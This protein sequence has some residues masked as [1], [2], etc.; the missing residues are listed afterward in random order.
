MVIL[1]GGSFDPIHNGHVLLIQNVIEKFSPQRFIVV[2]AYHGMCKN[3]C[4]FSREFR[5]NSVQKAL[6]E[7]PDSILKNIE[8]SDFELKQN[9]PV[10]TYET[11]EE[12]KPDTLLIGSDLDYTKWKNFKNVIDAYIKQILIYPRN[13][14]SP[15]PHSKKEIILN[16]P[17]LDVS[18]SEIISQLSRGES[19]KG[20]VPDS[21]LNYIEQEYLQ[22]N[23]EDSVPVRKI[24]NV[25]F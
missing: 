3:R 5:F 21:V 9:R 17:L 6:S 13:T 16:M 18:S 4:N 23:R 7:L 12:L 1:F 25:C 20:F 15:H 14:F 24:E 11:I 2:P 22:N 8:I 10:F 19:I